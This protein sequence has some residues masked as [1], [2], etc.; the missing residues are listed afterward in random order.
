MSIDYYSSTKVAITK[1]ASTSISVEVDGVGFADLTNG[2]PVSDLFI[3][4][5]IENYMAEA[6]II[7]DPFYLLTLRN[8]ETI[9]HRT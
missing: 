7:K 3:R 5:L 8:L 1:D 6:A 9:H 2:I 4:A